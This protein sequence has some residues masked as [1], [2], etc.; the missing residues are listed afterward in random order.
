MKTC[1][2]CKVEKPL[3]DFSKDRG[4]KKDGAN[5]W[6]KSCWRLYGQE[7]QAKIRRRKKCYYQENRIKFLH[8]QKKYKQSD[9][10]KATGKRSRQ[11][12]P[13]R[14]KA[15]QALCYAVRS[16]KMNRSVFCEKCGLPA[17]TDGHHADY[18]KPLEVEW[19]CKKCHVAV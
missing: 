12:Y 2:K 5:Y 3:T 11:K 9:K 13:E 1:S 4:N 10:G 8:K 14:C 6:C 18:S 15:V 17:E 19:L 7:N 16:G